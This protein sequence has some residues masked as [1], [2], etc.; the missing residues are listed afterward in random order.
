[1]ITTYPSVN[2]MF[3]VVSY[4]ERNLETTVSLPVGCF[5]KMKG[6][7]C[8]P[9]KALYGL[10]D[11]SKTWN[12]IF[13]TGLGFVRSDFEYCLYMKTENSSKAHLLVYIDDVL[14]ASNSQSQTDNLKLLLSGNFKIKDLGLIRNYLLMNI[15]QN[16]WE[17]TVAI[18]QSIYLE[19][20]LKV[21]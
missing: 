12:I 9:T 10:K 7:V 16:L 3:V 4:M 2:W 11:S 1:M 19:K 20:I 18:T 8:K 6:K 15:V 5:S 13:H 17:G 14:I 21:F